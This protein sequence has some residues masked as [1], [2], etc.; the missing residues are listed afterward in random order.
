M[1]GNTEE[2]AAGQEFLPGRNLLS[3]PY[4]LEEIL[5]LW[6]CAVIAH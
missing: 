1:Q 5:R 2:M 4:C 3:L 6:A